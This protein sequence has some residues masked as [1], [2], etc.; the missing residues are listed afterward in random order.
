MN[1]IGIVGYG[2]WGKNLVRNFNGF[3]SFD[4]VYVCKK[5][6]SLSDKCIKFYPN[7]KVVSDYAMLLNYDTVDAF[8]ASHIANNI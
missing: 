7:N 8:G 6:G 5:N 3:H 1:R 4:L 2:Y